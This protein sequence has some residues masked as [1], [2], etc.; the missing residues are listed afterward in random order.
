MSALDRQVIDSLARRSSTWVV[1]LTA[2]FALIGAAGA[3]LTGSATW[4]VWIPLWLL[5]VPT[6]SALC[7]EVRELRE[8]IARLEGSH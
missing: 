2:F 3:L 6:I 1:L 7:R 8:Q 4:A 5:T